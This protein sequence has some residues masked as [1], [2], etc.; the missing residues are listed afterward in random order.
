[1]ES[2]EY[3]LPSDISAV[4]GPYSFEYTPFFREPMRRLSRGPVKVGI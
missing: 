4:P 3:I 2:G 1:M